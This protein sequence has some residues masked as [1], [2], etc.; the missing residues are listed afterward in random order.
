VR[1]LAALAL[2]AGCGAGARTY[3][4][5]DL[6]VRTVT[7]DFNNAH[8]VTRG[9]NHLMIDAGLARSAA[10]LESALRKMHVDPRALKAL[11][12]THGHADH[13]G[14][15][16]HFQALG[17][18]VVAGEGDREMMAAGKNEP[19]FCPTD[20]LARLRLEEDA[21][22]T[23]TS[24]A[25]DLWVKEP[26]SLVDASGIDATVAPLPGHTRGSLVVVAGEVAFV[27]DLFR[28]A[29]VGSGATRHLYMCDLEDNRR[30]IHALLD[31]IAPHARHFYLGHFGPVTRAEVE[32]LAVELDASA[33]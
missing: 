26:L 5:G 31:T 12:L 20:L 13:A 24:T 3:R 18:R 27:G 32:A 16:R 19:P 6:V 22:Q 15:G 2:L 1:A 33:R 9:G 8:V 14:G 28:G 17:A 4:H 10:D 11:V 21:G 7:R 23:Y 29:A 25:A 30:D